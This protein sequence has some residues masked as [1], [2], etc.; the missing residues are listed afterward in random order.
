MIL[1]ILAV[2]TGCW[3]RKE[4]DDLAL[5]MASGIDVAEDGQ[6]EIT[7]QIALPT[8]I[9]SAVQSGG[10]GHKSFIVISAK[11]V[12]A[13]EASSRLQ[14]Q[15]SRAIY[16]G[17]RG[18]IVIGEQY[19]RRGLKQLLDT[20]TRLPESRYNGF[21][22]TTYGATAKEI[23][24]TPYQLELLPGIG[25]T[26]IQSSNLS[27]PVK[28]DDFVNAL[29]STGRS[30]VTAAIRIIHKDTA[31]ESFDIDRAA[32][33][34]ENKLAGFLEPD[35][36]KLLRWWRGVSNRLRYIVLVKR[37]SEQFRG[38]VSIEFLHSST[39]IKTTIKNGMPEVWTSFNAAVRLIDNDT[40]LD[41]SDINNMKTIE[42]EVSRSIHSQIERMLAH[43]QHDLKADILGIGEEIHIQ[44]PYAW[45]KIKDKW[46][47]MYPSVPVT[48][49]VHIQIQ[50]MGKTKAPA[51]KKTTE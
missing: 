8:G 18:V 36:L 6:I 42:K 31:S 24:S 14:Q 38:S 21:I 45:K 20:F 34:R 44:H 33:Y 32:A 39:K 16:F 2:L 17:H 27:F 12:S 28:I 5:V 19:A 23:L 50:R 48:A 40:S 11:G 51:H 46:S 41:M 10:K 7:L 1:C 26:K 9:P 49:E 35:E 4:M 13:S 29:T 43:L 25:I 47:D 3:D 22:V 30:P 37:E 15:L